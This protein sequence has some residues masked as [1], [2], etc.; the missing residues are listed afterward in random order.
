MSSTLNLEKNGSLVFDRIVDAVE[1]Y[2]ADQPNQGQL[3]GAAGIL[4][5]SA[6]S[7]TATPNTLELIDGNKHQ[8]GYEL[9]VEITSEQFYSVYEFEK[10]R[11]RKCYI[12][13]PDVPLWVMPVIINLEITFNPGE[14]KGQIKITGSKKAQTLLGC[15]AP[16][17]NGVVSEPYSTSVLKTGEQ[18]LPVDGFEFEYLLDLNNPDVEF[19]IPAVPDDDDEITELK[20]TMMSQYGIKLSTPPTGTTLKK[21][22]GTA[23]TSL[24]DFTVVYENGIYKVSFSGEAGL[25]LGDLVKVSY[26]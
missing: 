20:L 1:F 17:W 8:L 12:A 23:W 10:L 3:A 16:S 13:L 25:A 7:I 5:K 21:W 2:H 11:N 6:V 24:T 9:K 26:S 4:G 15:V 22:N 19:I 14:S 18:K